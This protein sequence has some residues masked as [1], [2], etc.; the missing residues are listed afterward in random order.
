MKIGDK[1]NKTWNFIDEDYG[2]DD[3]FD[4]C[5]VIVY[6]DEELFIVL[7]EEGTNTEVAINGMPYDDISMM[8]D[9]KLPYEIDRFTVFVPLDIKHEEFLCDI[10][11]SWI[12]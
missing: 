12:H 6:V 4:L 5:G 10:N 7:A 9:I 2:N 1:Y 3:S 11:G 8:Y